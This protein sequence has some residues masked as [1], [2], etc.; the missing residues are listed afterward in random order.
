MKQGQ[1]V[2]LVGGVA[3]GASTA[4]RLRRLDE[5]ARIILFERGAHI[6]FANCGLPYYIGGEIQDKEA[7][8]VQT[9]EDFKGKFAVDIRTFHEVTS[10]DPEK[11]CVT[12]K[13]VLSGEV[14]EESYDKLVLS[15]GAE[16]IRPPIPGADS[17]RVFTLRN[18]P[19]TY[20][21]KDFMET[22][23]PTSA[24]IMGGG[25][26]GVELAENLS[27]AGIQVTL[28]EMANQI[29][30]PLDMDM[31]A[32]VQAHIKS[33]GVR[34]EL[35]N[36]VQEIRETA[37]G[38]TVSLQHG[39]IEA[40]FLIMAIG[41]RPETSLAREAGLALNARG[42]ILVD[43]HL[44]TSDPHIY[45]LGDAVEVMNSIT[46]EKAH[47]PL[48]GP[49]N[50]QGRIVA[51]NL[52]GFDS[53]YIGTQ[54]SSILKVFDMTVASTGINEKTAKRLGLSYDKAFTYSSNH[55]DYYPGASKMSI[56]TI[57]ELGTGR[58]LGAQIVGFEGVDK[59]C[60]I[61]A[62]AIRAK[63]TAYDLCKLELCYAPPYN[64]AKDPVNMVGFVIE[65]LLTGKVKQFHWHDV[66]D[67][68]RDGSVTLLDVRL[69]EEYE[70]G[71][72][73]GF[74]NLPL[75]QIRSR[76]SELD[77]NKKLY[78]SCQ[79]GL[80]AYHAARILAQNGFDVSILAGSYRLY[81][82]AAENQ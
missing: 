43:E 29:L 39:R 72:I 35:E 46:G 55:A 24:V 18:I 42:A 49:A 51:D 66:A 13:E 64:S 2:L 23:K 32:E 33:K 59:R 4:A 26:I 80:K 74:E 20:R 61:L 1:K 70:A 10:I 44:Q 28:V 40:D 78:V 56:K 67:L 73:E 15:M 76:L 3:G 58:I 27:H 14:Y 45:A 81:Q 77:P 16:P 60:D 48:A 12:V 79:I 57:F 50:K 37:D 25:F 31:A 47:V 69:P 36:G 30:A 8:T 71:H 9:P 62:V 21:M 53:T 6:S 75:G 41:V 17:A 34:L 22:Q 38:L 52:C 5:H 63:M 68:P 82:L 7:L 11:K 54:G 19:D 65:N